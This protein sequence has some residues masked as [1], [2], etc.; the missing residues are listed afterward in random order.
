MAKRLP[1]FAF[2]RGIRI[3]TAYDDHLG[4]HERHVVWVI[5]RLDDGTPF[6]LRYGI[7]TSWD[8]QVRLGESLRK[9]ILDGLRRQVRFADALPDFVI[10][11][12]LT[13]M[14]YDYAA[15]PERVDDP[16]W[17]EEDRIEREFRDDVWRNLYLDDRDSDYVVLSVPYVERDQ[18]KAAGAV[19]NG[20]LRAWWVNRPADLS[21]FS[22]WLPAEP[23]SPAP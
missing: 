6:N 14:R 12:D 11:H 9:K 1:G 8:C 16:L 3:R 2:E 5:G 4:T 19:W 7:A 20:R 17:V 10:D 22:R 13:A 23:A 21:A 18:A 15:Y